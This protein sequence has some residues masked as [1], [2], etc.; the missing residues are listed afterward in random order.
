MPMVGT[1]VAAAWIAHIVFWALLSL[2]FFIGSM[3][4]RSI[5][6]FIVLWLLGYLGM[7]RLGASG[8]PLIAPYVAVLDIVLVL[9]VFRGDVRLS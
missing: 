7:P 8:G 3:S 6:T 5:W 2:C 4:N 1:P 9:V